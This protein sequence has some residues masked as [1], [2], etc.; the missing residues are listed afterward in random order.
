VIVDGTFSS[1]QRIARK[2]LAQ[3]WL[4][5]LGQPLVYVLLSDRWVPE[6]A[7]ISPTPMIVLHGK[8]DPIVEFEYGERVFQEAREPKIFIEV[9][10]GRHGDLFW[11]A[12]GKYRKLVLDQLE[13][14]Q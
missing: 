11:V 1:F 14:F 4:T 10:E 13:A 3:H 8:L 5:W 9:P 12:G 7:K 2:K 6:V